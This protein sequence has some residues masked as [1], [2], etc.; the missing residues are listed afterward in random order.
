[1]QDNSTSESGFSLASLAGLSTYQIGD[2]GTVMLA[3]LNVSLKSLSTLLY[4]MFY[5]C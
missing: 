3:S 4:G 2:M 5:S 1:M